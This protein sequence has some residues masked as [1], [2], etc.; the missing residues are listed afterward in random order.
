MRAA[1]LVIVALFL[2]AAGAP[3][4]PGVLTIADFVTMPMTGSPTGTG[5][6]GSLARVNVM[7]EEPGGTGRLFVSDLNGPFYILDK[8]T[9][10][11][12]T[13]LDFNGRDERPGLF[14]KLPYRPAIRTASSASQFDPDYARNGSLLH[15]S[16]RRTGRAGL[17][18][19]GQHEHSRA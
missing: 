9:K 7:R 19:A 6:V 4:S 18:H 8:K 11:L 10:A 17:D 14:D 15:D 13:Y 12:A 1:S 16:P 5:N 2:Q 3:P